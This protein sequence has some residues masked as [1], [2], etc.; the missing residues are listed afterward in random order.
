MNR[1]ILVLTLSVVALIVLPACGGTPT[2]QAGPAATAQP[3]PTKTAPTVQPT[4]V[5][6]KTATA[7]PKPTETQVATSTPRP[8]DTPKP[9]DTPI[10]TITVAPPTRTPTPMPPTA[11]AAPPTKTPIPVSPTSTPQPLTATAIPGQAS[12]EITNVFYDGVNG[13]NEPDEFAEITNVGAVPVNLKGWRLNAGA[14]GQDFILP[15]FN[16]QQGQSCR[17]Y[18]NENHPESCGF[19]FGSKQALWNNGGDCGY[20]YDATSALV[21]KCCY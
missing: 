3:G 9:T 17:I 20:L 6:A 1:R 14:P 13:R 4:S 21:D 19:S 8:T 16:L 7:L 18:T 2:P 10:P 5:I 15:E 11:T 12:V